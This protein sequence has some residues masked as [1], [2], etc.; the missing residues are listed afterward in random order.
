MIANQSRMIQ[1][2]SQALTATGSMGP[3]RAI[4]LASAVVAGITTDQDMQSLILALTAG[5]DD[6]DDD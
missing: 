3:V 2:L 6:S 5:A 1:E 4:Q